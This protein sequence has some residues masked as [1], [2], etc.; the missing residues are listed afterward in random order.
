M[1]KD[2]YI[3]IHST[4]RHSCLVSV[5]KIVILKCGDLP[6]NTKVL[7]TGKLQ[8]NSANQRS[9]MELFEGNVHI[10]HSQPLPFKLANIW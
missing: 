7:F 4:C 1:F 10:N 8:F 2:T 3:T 6:R 9:F 5:F